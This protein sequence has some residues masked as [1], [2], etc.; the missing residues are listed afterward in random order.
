MVLTIMQ[1]AGYLQRLDTSEARIT[2]RYQHVGLFKQLLDHI[3]SI[4]SFGDH[5]RP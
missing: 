2:A 1:A 4:F 5:H 3:I